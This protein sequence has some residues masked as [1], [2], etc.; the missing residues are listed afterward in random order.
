MHYAIKKKLEQKLMHIY[1]RKNEYALKAM[2][3]KIRIRKHLCIN[4]CSNLLKYSHLS[5]KRG[6]HDYPF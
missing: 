6:A 3:V 4:V 1:S 2:K 5:N